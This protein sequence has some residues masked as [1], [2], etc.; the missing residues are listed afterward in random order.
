MSSRA[1]R[2]SARRPAPSLCRRLCRANRPSPRLFSSR[3]R[4]RAGCSASC[5]TSTARRA[6]R[7]SCRRLR[8]SARTLRRTRSRS[9]CRSTDSDRRTRSPTTPRDP[10]ESAR[11]IP[12]RN[13]SRHT[14]CRR[15]RT[16][17][18]SRRCATSLPRI[19]RSGGRWR[20]SRDRRGTPRGCA[21]RRRTR[22][23]RDRCASSWRCMSGVAP[24][25]R[26]A[27]VSTRS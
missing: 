4:E 3:P 24:G 27:S 21:R 22:R 12:R 26:S 14:C 7:P 2:R 5:P 10:C 6:S 8:P 23:A 17:S 13:A 25:H 1:A 15:C 11:S 9:R 16:T 20:G 19:R 18:A